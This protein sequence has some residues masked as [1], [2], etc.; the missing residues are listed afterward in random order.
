MVPNGMNRRAFFQ[1]A[2]AAIATVAIGVRLQVP[3]PVAPQ[4]YFM[5][6]INL[7][8]TEIQDRIMSHTLD[9]M[10]Y[11]MAGKGEAVAWSM[12]YDSTILNSGWKIRPISASEF[13]A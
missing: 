4:Q 12:W 6:T 13:Y 3:L 10:R 7:T 5:R 11:M 9:S 8:A 2:A 1:H